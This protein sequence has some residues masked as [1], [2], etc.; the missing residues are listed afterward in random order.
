MTRPDDDLVGAAP[1]RRAWLDVL[2][3]GAAE[4]E[5]RARAERLLDELSTWVAAPTAH[6]DG[7]DLAAAR[8]LVRSADVDEAARLCEV[9]LAAT[10]GTLLHADT[11]ASWW[12]PRATA[13]PAWSRLAALRGRL[14]SLPEPPAA[15]EAPARIVRR[16]ASWLERESLPSH[17]AWSVRVAWVLDGAAAGLERWEQRFGRGTLGLRPFSER[18]ASLVDGVELC[19]DLGRVARA[20]ELLR[21]HPAEVAT[22]GRLVQLLV[23]CELAVGAGERA[24]RLW[25]E[26]PQRVPHWPAPVAALRRR[27]PWVATML[28]ARATCGLEPTDLRAPPGGPACRGERSEIG[29]ARLA[30]VVHTASSAGLAVVHQEGVVGALAAR[31]ARAVLEPT[32]SSR[33]CIERALASGAPRVEVHGLS[34]SGPAP[35]RV[36]ATAAVP[37]P[38]EVA[39]GALLLE[40][41]H[42]LVP[43]DERLRRFAAAC[44]ARCA[45]VVTGF[46]SRAAEQHVAESPDS[47]T[48]REPV[49]AAIADTAVADATVDLQPAPAPAPRGPARGGATPTRRHPRSGHDLGAATGAAGVLARLEGRIAPN[50]EG[51]VDRLAACLPE[52]W[53][54]RPWWL[55]APEDPLSVVPWPRVAAPHLGA[56]GADAPGPVSTGLAVTGACST[57]SDSIGPDSIGPDSTHSG[58]AA[59]SSRGPSTWTASAA[60]WTADVRGPSEHG[61]HAGA[62]LRLVARGPRGHAALALLGTREA[63]VVARLADGRA[64]LEHDVDP[65]ARLHAEGRSRAILPLVFAG[66]TLALLVVEATRR[67]EL[68]Q[69]ALERL[70]PRV[71]ELGVDLFWEEL[72]RRHH[73]RFG[74]ALVGTGFVVDPVEHV[75]ALAA[76]QPVGIAGPRGSGKALLGRCAHLLAGDGAAFV[77][78]RATQLHAGS[79]ADEIAAFAGSAGATVLVRRVD[80]VE[81]SLQREFAD[82]LDGCARAALARGPAARA[83]RLVWTAVPD[84][85]VPELRARVSIELA[86]LAA[87]RRRIPALATA[88]FARAAARLGVAAG[89]LDDSALACLWRAPWHGGVAELDRVLGALASGRPRLR[90]G[91]VDV[92]AAAREAAVPMVQRL[93]SRRP[94]RALLEEALATTAL[95]GGR[96]N[97]R[98]AALYLGW[99]RDTLRERL[100]EAGLHT[101]PRRDV[102]PR[103][104]ARREPAPTEP[105]P[106]EPDPTES[107]QADR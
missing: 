32:S 93:P 13:R 55:V 29:A 45:H 52:A 68:G 38:A 3:P 79:V 103:E 24:R 27:V 44:A 63:H 54:G 35:E 23:W 48:W 98:R 6:V 11:F 26:A 90:H 56:P 62:R 101:L 96:A 72:S 36:R 100:L 15:G 106:A 16:L 40:F 86:P 65:A 34:E 1:T 84:E 50:L 49:D 9:A 67:G 105:D 78:C 92:E 59:P 81:A 80:R 99:D 61:V 17:E 71:R 47:T 58:A 69:A 77:E 7:L 12:R 14:A 94:P 83:L 18:V 19:L 70:A 28:D 73:A 30:F 21:G 8:A 57:G 102:E 107:E 60:V 5:R 104:P 66:H 39:R 31:V 2:L 88:L 42:L 43:S 91:A 10:A 75:L 87:Q 41:E 64:C 76:P 53:R 51:V 85:L 22:D 37:L 4:A 20:L 95:H 33:T 82:L 74:E 97:Q 25:A 89:R 46:A